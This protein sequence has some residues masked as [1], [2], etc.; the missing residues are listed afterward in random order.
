M[1]KYLTIEMEF[2]DDVDVYSDAVQDGMVQAVMTTEGVLGARVVGTGESSTG[3]SL[4]EDDDN[5]A[6]A[7]FAKPPNA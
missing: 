1:A 5:A 3:A 2:A 6:P 4:P 7:D